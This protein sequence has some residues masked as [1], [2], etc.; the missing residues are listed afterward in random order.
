MPSEMVISR[1]MGG[2]PASTWRRVR[3]QDLLFLDA[4]ARLR[5]GGPLVA[6]TAARRLHRAAAPDRAPCGRAEVGCC[7]RGPPGRAG[8]RARAHARLGHQRLAGTDRS[9]INRLAGNRARWAASGIPG[10]G[11]A[12]LRRHRP[13]GAR[14]AWPP[15]RDAAAPP[16]APPAG[17]PAVGCAG[18]AGAPDGAAAR[19]RRPDALGARARTAAARTR[20]RHRC[21]G[22]G[23]G[24]F[25]A[26][27]GGNG[28]RGPERI[29]PGL[30]A[31]AGRAA[32][33][34]TGGRPDG[35]ARSRAGG[36]RCGGAGAG[37]GAVAARRGRPA[38]AGAGRGTATWPPTGGWIGRPPPAA[39]G[40][41]PRRRGAASRPARRLRGWRGSR[42]P[43]GC[44]ARLGL[45]R[46]GAARRRRFGGRRLGVSRRLP[47][48]SPAPVSGSG[49]AH[50]C[51][52]SRRSLIATSSSM[53]LECVFFSVTPSSGS[54][55]RIS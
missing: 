29:W 41:A 17:P 55:S 14:R 4:L 10:R 43:R 6:G 48:R 9:A 27:A 21:A 54:R 3:P 13:A 52:Y 40:S 30:G 2:G 25:G 50:R 18:A 42:R 15:D 34:P 47:R 20:R 16:A 37:G 46:A 8:G 12:G 11:G 5:T 19:G 49:R 45:L 39:A 36:R 32:A 22:P 51:P 31:G 33:W 28:W 1:L 23:R 24:A 53:E 26:G 7:G 44:P 38:A 35:R